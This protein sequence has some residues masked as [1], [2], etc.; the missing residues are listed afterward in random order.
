[1]APVLS[2]SLA[3]QSLASLP[4]TNPNKAFNLRSAFLPRSGLNKAFSCTGLRWK[5]EKR[6][7]RTA[8]RCEA[9]AVAKKEA[10]E[11][12]GGKFEYQA[13]V[14]FFC[15]SWIFSFV[16]LFLLGFTWWVYGKMK[17]NDVTWCTIRLENYCFFYWIELLLVNGRCSFILTVFVL[18]FLFWN[19][20]KLTNGFRSV[21]CWIWLFTVYTATKRC[22]WESL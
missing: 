20:Y 11:T 15:I 21:A 2:R 10:E 8:V 14:G 16:I 6:N 12:S 17:E 18:Y 4:L 7:N 22:F 13:E 5:L 1:M 19:W 9:S 3:T